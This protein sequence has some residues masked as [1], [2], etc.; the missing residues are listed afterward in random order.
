MVGFVFYL[1][2]LFSVEIWFH[3]KTP[4]HNQFFFI[5]FLLL[6][7]EGRGSYLDSSLWKELAMLLSHNTLGN[8]QVFCSFLY[9]MVNMKRKIKL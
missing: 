6:T 9:A 5:F 8:N 7:S 1:N 4:I 3:A 2:L